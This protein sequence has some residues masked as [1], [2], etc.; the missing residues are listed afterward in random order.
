MSKYKIFL[1]DEVAGWLLMR[2]AGL[3]KEQTQLIQTTVGT[4]T[5]VEKVEKALYLTLGQKPQGFLSCK[6][7]QHAWSMEV[8]PCPLC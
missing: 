6:V 2:R 1:P 8:R 4:E 5:T 7:Q 3:T